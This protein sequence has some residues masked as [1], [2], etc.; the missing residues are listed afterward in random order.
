R[1][2]APLVSGELLRYVLALP[3]DYKI[4]RENGAAIEK[5]V[6][7]KAYEAFL[8]PEISGR[9]KQE[10]SQ[11]S[12]VASLLPA[13]VEALLEDGELEAVQ[14]D[15]PF[16]RSKEELYYFRIFGEHFGFGLAVES[17]GQW[18]PE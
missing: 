4:R 8:P 13:R 10:F 5:W 18:I 6:L 3:A 16:I 12:G 1:V 7:R 15:F 11:G 2:V 14:A 17:V 9:T